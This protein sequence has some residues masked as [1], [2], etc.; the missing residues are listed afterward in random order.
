MSCVASWAA[1]TGTTVQV[2]PRP[3]SGVLEADIVVLATGLNLQMLGGAEVTVDGARVN[4]G[5]HYTYKGAMLSEVPNL[6]FVFG[7]TNASWTLRADLILEYACRLINYMDEYGLASAT[8][9]IGEAKLEPSK[10]EGTV[11]NALP[12]EPAPVA[13]A[14]PPDTLVEDA[15]GTALDAFYAQ[16]ARTRAKEPG[17]VTRKA[18]NG[19]APDSRRGARDRDHLHRS[20]K[21]PSADGEKRRNYASETSTA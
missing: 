15:T 12:D 5:E 10:N 4:T 7:Y 6:V 11:T 2:E 3:L 1:R 9:H 19:G 14:A 17:A 20:P 13:V 18:A 8:P 16:L 21:Y